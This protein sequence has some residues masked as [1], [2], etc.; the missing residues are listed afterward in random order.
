M[1][2]HDAL[3]ATFR[4]YAAA[5]LEPFDVGPVLYGLTDQVTEVLGADGAGVSLGDGDRPLTFVTATDAAIATIE[6][7]Q[8]VRES[9]PCHRAF[10]SGT[11]VVCEDLEADDRF[12]GYCEV[13]LA[14]GVRAVLGIPM[15][16]GVQRIGA[17]NVYWHAPHVVT[18]DEVQ[19]AQ[20]L[21]DMAS[22]Y[23]LN[24]TRVERSETLAHQLQHALDSRV[25]IEQA[26]GILAERH[27]LS[28]SEAFHRLRQRARSS[29]RR[30]HDVA[31]DIVAGHAEA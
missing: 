1:I 14:N 31:T 27:H 9:G 29:S 20:L 8:A 18:D 2:H 10:R 5:L 19:I 4:T 6:E 3:V 21:A 22:G 13:A 24:A 7:E 30:V 17:L 28:P 15:P 23:I 16:V 11:A 12:P 26:K 25:V